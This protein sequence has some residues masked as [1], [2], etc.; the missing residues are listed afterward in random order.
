MLT[1]YT[2]HRFFFFLLLFFFFYIYRISE[3]HPKLSPFTYWPGAMINLQRLE[4]PMSRTNFHGPKDVRAIE[5]RLF[6]NT[7]SMKTST[8]Q[9]ESTL[10]ISK[11]KGLPEIL[12]ISNLIPEVRDI[13]KILSSFPQYFVTCC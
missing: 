3:R 13:L 10:V 2:Q 11:S 1:G 6:I 5:V 4:L 9:I 8:S 12:R 7:V